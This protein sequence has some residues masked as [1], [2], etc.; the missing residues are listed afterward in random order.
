MTNLYTVLGFL[1]FFAALYLLAAFR[2]DFKQLNVHQK[3]S[4]TL[5]IVLA[6]A[7][8]VIEFSMGFINA[9]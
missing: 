8:T 4:I 3:F 7:P 2:D 9:F 6:I 5:F 1:S